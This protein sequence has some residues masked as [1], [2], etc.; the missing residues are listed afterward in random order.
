VLNAS[1]IVVQVAAGGVDWPAVAASIATGVAAVA[2]IA[3][4]L[5]LAGR[6]WS[7]DDKKDVIAEKRR[8]YANFLAIFN[9]AFNL[10]V[11]VH[12]NSQ[13]NS[14]DLDAI[15]KA[16]VAIANSRK[17]FYELFLIVPQNV[18]TL[19]SKAMNELVNYVSNDNSTNL[20]SALANLTK[21]MRVDLGAP[22][23]PSSVTT[24]ALKSNVDLSQTST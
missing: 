3:G 5:F 1:P 17:A 12:S 6:N 19:G 22:P 8:V 15:N 21:A 2:G 13:N 16:T 10:L 18:E 4:S 11:I 9:E 24:D 23:F 14:V 20:G 7:H